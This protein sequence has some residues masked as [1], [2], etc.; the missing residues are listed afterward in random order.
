MEIER[1]FLIGELPPPES[2]PEPTAILQGYLETGA[3]GTEVRL[4]HR[5]NRFSLTI[6]TGTGLR[7]REAEVSLSAGQ[8]EDLWP[9]TEGRRVEKT[10]MRSGIGVG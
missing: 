1:R 4:R 3:A 10:A 8:F 5:R 2:L 7:R 9:A 6:K